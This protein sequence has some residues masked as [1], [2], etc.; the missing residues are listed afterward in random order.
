MA[1]FLGTVMSVVQVTVQMAA[2]PA[3]LGAGAAS[4]QYSRSMGAALG[5]AL[6]AAVL[7]A[8][9]S[10]LDP[11]A[12]RL[13][14]EVLQ[15]GTAVLDSLPAARSQIIQGEFA[16]SFRAAFL[17]IAGIAALPRCWSG[18]CRCGGSESARAMPVRR[19]ATSARRDGSSAQ[20]QP[21]SQSR[22]SIRSPGMIRLTTWA[23]TVS[24]RMMYT[25]ACK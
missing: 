11:E 12:G 16:Q 24:V 2:G 22:P 23:S 5:T 9:L 4:V 6:V 1:L 25:T 7:F 19:R 8:T 15:N 17:A 3:M 13:F 14:G 10:S 21:A 20:A 18:R